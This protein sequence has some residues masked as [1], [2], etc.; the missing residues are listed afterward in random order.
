MIFSLAHRCP[1]S[2]RAAAST[3]RCRPPSSEAKSV[4]SAS[5][6]RTQRYGYKHALIA[7]SKSTSHIPIGHST[8]S[9]GCASR[10]PDVRRYTHLSGCGHSD[11]SC[12]AL[13]RAPLLPHKVSVMLPSGR[14]SSMSSP[15]RAANRSLPLRP[16][17]QSQRC[18]P[19]TPRPLRSRA[20]TLN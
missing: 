12:R 7:L 2:A 1:H 16:M 14:T 18:D 17:Q 11:C 8:T 15:P 10:D 4:G 3:Q 9:V 6:S 13:Q 5:S 20:D 19:N